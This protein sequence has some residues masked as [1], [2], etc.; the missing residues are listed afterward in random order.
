M[1]KNLSQLK[2]RLVEG[3]QFSIAE[4]RRADVVGERRVVN[5]ADTTG[6][7]TLKLN[8]SGIP[9]Q[10]PNSGR[11]SFLSWGK[12]A[13]WDFKEDGVCA[14]YSNSSNKTTETLTIAIR[15]FD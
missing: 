2:K 3:T 8:E 10:Q 9:I 7:Y 11:G 1:I 15:V 12:A 14:H 4:H 6:I 13:S 5:Y